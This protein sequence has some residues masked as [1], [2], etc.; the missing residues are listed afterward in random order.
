[1]FRRVA[2]VV[3]VLTLTA[4]GSSN[5]EPTTTTAAPTTSTTPRPPS[6]VATAEN[7]SL[8]M[9]AI[10]DAYRVRLWDRPGFD[11]YRDL[12]QIGDDPMST[13][14]GGD[15]TVVETV[16]VVPQTCAIFAGACCEPVAGVTYYGGETTGEWKM[17]FGRLPTVSPDGRHVA[18]VGWEALSVHETDSPE[19]EVASFKIPVGDSTVMIDSMWIDNDRIVL[20]G[21]TKVGTYIWLATMSNGDI[22]PAVLVSTKVNSESP[23]ITAVHLGGTDD[24]G[25]IVVLRPVKNGQQ[26]LMLAP[27]MMDATSTRAFPRP[28]IAY[29]DNG[30]RTVEVD[31]DG[32]LIVTG[33]DGSAMKFGRG[34]LWAR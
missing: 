12:P 10:T 20:M 13:E 14:T 22:R 31:S 6:C 3:G 29:F 15:L 1:M 25:N 33:E 27:E 7:P 23:D 4:C 9:A 26:L 8:G 24:K 34:F 30:T 17:I 16:A 5:S 21:Y 11:G 28:L 32:G 19:T 2:I 18:V